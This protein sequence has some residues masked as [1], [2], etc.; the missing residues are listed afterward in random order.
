MGLREGYCE[1]SRCL[2]FQQQGDSQS[3]SREL[4]DAIDYA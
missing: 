3:L 2:V 4:L 1:P